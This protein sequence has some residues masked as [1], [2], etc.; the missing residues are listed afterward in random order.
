[1]P[2]SQNR[3]YFPKSK[4]FE[5]EVVHTMSDDNTKADRKGHCHN[6]QQASGVWRLAVPRGYPLIVAKQDEA[7]T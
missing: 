3:W 2:Y 5:K 4:V 6:P 1:M 7:P